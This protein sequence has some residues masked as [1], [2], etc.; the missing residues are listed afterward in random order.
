M[1]ECRQLYKGEALYYWGIF[2]GSKYRLKSGVRVMTIFSKSDNHYIDLLTDIHSDRGVYDI[3]SLEPI[4][5]KPKHLAKK[6][7]G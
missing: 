3:L 7:R 2:H 6:I 1:K 4:L 5:N